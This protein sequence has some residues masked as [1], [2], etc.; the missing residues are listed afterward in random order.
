M[1]KPSLLSLTAA[2]ACFTLYAQ[3][4]DYRF[5]KVSADEL[6]MTSY[7]KDPDAAA[8]YLYEENSLFYQIDREIGLTSDYRARIKILKSDGTDQ[9]NVSIPYTDEYSVRESVFGID[10]VAY[11]LVDGKIVKTPLKKQYVFTEQVDENR[12]LVKFSIPE[13]REGT[14]IEYKFRKTSKNPI[15][16]PSFRFQHDIPVA[17]CHMQALIPEFF[18]FNLNLKGYVKINIEDGSTNGSVGS[19]SEMFSFNVREIKADATDIPA[20][21]REAYVWCLN[22]FRS[23][24][25]FELSQIAFPGVPIRSYTSTWEN[26]NDM[27]KK[28]SFDTHC[29]IGNPFKDEVAAIKA[30]EGSP[31]EK[32]H[33]VLRL[34]QSK[35]KWN[36]KY[37]LFSQGPRAAAGKGSGS[38][39]DINFVLMAA[40][41]DAGFQVT[42]ILLSPRHMGRIPYTHPTIDGIN[43]FVVRV[44]L[45]EGKYAYVDGTN[46]NSDIDLLPT[47][48]LVDRARVYG[49]NDDS[50]WCD[51][52]GIAKNASVINMILKLDTEGTVSGE[53]IEQHLNQPALLANTAYTDA[54]SHEEY[55]ESLE[56]EHGIRI[57]ELNLEGTG[58]KKLVQKYRMSSQPSGTDEFLYVNA[59]IVPF[60]STNRLNAQSRTLPIEFSY[61]MVYSIRCSLEL[62]EGYTVEEMPKNINILAYEKGASCKYIAQAV[63]KYIQ[64]RFQYSIERIV[65][66][67]SEFE[68]LNSFLGMVADLSNS[69][70]V[71]R[72][73]TPQP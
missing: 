19:G 59:T 49:V 12:K 65:Y 66:L 56:K 2:F 18:K 57:E 6:R 48:L 20:L 26:V 9:A 13:V 8:V 73:N 23:M 61:P 24:L 58:T 67:P 54:K 29:R 3:T 50:G 52:T 33:A 17:R 5:G 44:A 53:F 43:A 10:A 39:A 27:L 60:M 22:D 68:N 34:V 1:K 41:K 36:E 72:K 32:I 30:G 45:D 16:I 7:D 11:N 14:V 64:F 42:P 62:P 25:E 37:R 38:S 46:P 31:G 70:F 69:Q 35:M 21:K 15:Y 47:E 4:P 55:V 71:I 51:L 63:G 28:S 40:L